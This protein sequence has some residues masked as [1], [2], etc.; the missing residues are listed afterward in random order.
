[1]R[2]KK[3]QKFYSSVNVILNAKPKC[4]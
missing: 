1:L 2:I 4:D 3:I